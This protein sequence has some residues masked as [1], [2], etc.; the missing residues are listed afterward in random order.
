MWRGLPRLRLGV[1]VGDAELDGADA[2]LGE[3][4]EGEE[5]E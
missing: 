4:W 5:G 1:A 2:V 3:Q